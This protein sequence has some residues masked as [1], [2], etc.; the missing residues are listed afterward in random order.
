MKKIM[1]ILL[2]ILTA[3][4]LLSGCGGGGNPANKGGKD[5]GVIRVWVGEESAEFYQKTCDEYLA[6]HPQTR[7]PRLTFTPLR[8][9][10][11]GSLRQR[12]A[13]SRS[14]TRHWSTRCWR[15]TRNPT[16]ASFIPR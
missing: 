14:Q 6:A 12:S 7:K 15:T 5:D 4:A 3:A 2:A 10:T 9:T 16:A 11:S 8:T 1:S 13:R